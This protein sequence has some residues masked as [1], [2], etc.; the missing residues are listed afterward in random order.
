MRVCRDDGSLRDCLRIRFCLH[1][2][3]LSVASFVQWT[4]PSPTNESET[5]RSEIIRRSVYPRRSDSD[6]SMPMTSHQSGENSEKSFDSSTD[7]LDS[8]LHGIAICCSLT[9]RFSL[10]A[11][12]HP[13]I[14]R[15]FDELHATT[16]CRL[17]SATSHTLAHLSGD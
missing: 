8:R 4:T 12:K 17:F 14:F 9:F 15:A 11:V 5:N 13:C 6:S 3:Q 10:S 16:A 7:R 1:Q 2:A